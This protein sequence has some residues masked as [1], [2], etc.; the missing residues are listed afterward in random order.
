MRNMTIDYVM[1][2][3]YLLS[4]GGAPAK[5]AGSGGSGDR[6]GEY[7]Q[8]LPALSGGTHAPVPSLPVAYGLCFI[9]LS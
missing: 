4:L 8:K 7:P 9:I 3:L 2:D 1:G 5:A 6:A